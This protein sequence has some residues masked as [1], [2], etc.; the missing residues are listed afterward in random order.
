MTSDKSPL[1]KRRK[2]MSKEI[3]ELKQL[4]SK[5]DYLEMLK[6]L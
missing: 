4:K 2:A 3:S 6:G 1:L 5:Q